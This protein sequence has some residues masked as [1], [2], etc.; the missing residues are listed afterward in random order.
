MAKKQEI[1]T[2]VPEKKEQ[3]NRRDFM[4]KAVYA[5]PTLMALG[6]LLRPTEAK[7]GF[8]KPPSGPVWN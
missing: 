4:K 6:G 1:L 2:S 3:T 8:G 7:A 5:T